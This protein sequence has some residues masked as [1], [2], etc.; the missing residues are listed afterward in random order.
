VIAPTELASDY[1]QRAAAL[2]RQ[3]GLAS[4]ADGD[5]EAPPLVVVAGE[6]KRGKS[7][8]VNALLGQ[9]GLA[10]SGVDV[11]TSAPVMF[12]FSA[13]EEA[14]VY[15]FGTDEPTATLPAD[16]CTLATA[17]GAAGAERAVRAVEIG[18][19]N[20]LLR[21]VRLATPR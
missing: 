10:P 14:R 7:T 8:L 18:L 19:D 4:S 20:P 1:L 9:P 17:E 12:S 11:V 6:V 13:V 3:P 21:H 5:G 2:V 15:W 16:A